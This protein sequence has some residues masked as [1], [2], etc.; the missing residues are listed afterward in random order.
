MPAGITT[1][2]SFMTAPGAWDVLA[3]KHASARVLVSLVG[4]PADLAE[5]RAWT[6]PAGPQWVFYLPDLRLLGAREAVRAAFREKRLL[7]IVLA[8]PGAPPESEPLGRDRAAEVE[9]RYLLVTAE[10]LEERIAA[11]PRLFP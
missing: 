10:N 4:V 8:R 2:I 7:A 11:W 9:K 6:D 5:T 3:A 1:P